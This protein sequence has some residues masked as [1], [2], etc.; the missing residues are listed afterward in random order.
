MISDSLQ[1]GL[2]AEGKVLGVESSI[3]ADSGWSLNEVDSMMAAM[4][5]QS[6]YKIPACK[7]I[8]YGVRT[9][10][11]PPTATRAPGMINGAAMIEAVLEHA[12]AEMGV[13]S[14]DLR[15]NNMMEQGDITLP[16]PLTL[17]TPNPIPQMIAD[18]QNSADF[19]ARQTAVETF[20][21]ANKWKKRGL[22]L[23]PFRYGHNLGLW[24]G[25]YHYYH[26]HYYYY[27]YLLLLHNVPG[28]CEVPLPDLGV[29]R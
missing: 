28:R 19:T 15:L 10:T 17:Q 16:P 1:I 9:D 25:Y 5:G 20:N 8:P 22:S 29:R 24:S 4:F 11:C 6:C 12:A 13:N 2:S 14:L 23:V 3:Y 7:Y 26:H 21:A 18:L 27:Y